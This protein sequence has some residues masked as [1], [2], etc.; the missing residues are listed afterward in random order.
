MGIFNDMTVPVKAISC[1]VDTVA[2]T[3]EPKDAE[4]FL[5][6]V[7][8]LNWPAKTLS[9]ELGKRGV[10]ISETPIYNHRGKACKCWKI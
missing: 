7:M 3:L 5:E 4:K 6:L 8:D 9:R 10:A 2:R 1:K